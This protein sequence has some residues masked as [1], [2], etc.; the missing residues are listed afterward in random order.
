M[1]KIFYVT[2]LFIC[3]FFLSGCSFNS[4][5]YINLKSKPSNDYYTQELNNALNSS[6]DFSLVVFDS[7]YYK[8]MPVDDEDKKSFKSFL[9]S[10]KD[11]NFT[12]E[13]IDSSKKCL[14]RVYVTIDNTKYQIKVFQDQYVS[15]APW[16]GVF[17]EDVLKEESIPLGN[18]LTTFCNYI[19][20]KNNSNTSKKN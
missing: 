3:L 13:A 8:Q 15:I 5:Q 7:N 4:S 14:F 9:K 17:K 18:K 16:D 2:F 20:D 19:L 11:D 12:E 6:E 1:R 10:I